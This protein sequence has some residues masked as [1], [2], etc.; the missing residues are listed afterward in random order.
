MREVLQQVH[1]RGKCDSPTQESLCSCR[2]KQLSTNDPEAKWIYIRK[3][4]LFMVNKKTQYEKTEALSA[5]K[6]HKSFFLLTK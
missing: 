1:Q 3:F 5:A 2:T 6:C 4:K